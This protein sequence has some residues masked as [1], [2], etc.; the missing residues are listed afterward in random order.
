MMRQV[1]HIIP[2]LVMATMAVSC[3]KATQPEEAQATESNTI[4][5]DFAT[6]STW[7][8]A[9]SRAGI[10]IT[11]STTAG[12]YSWD[13]VSNI[14]ATN[15]KIYCTDDAANQIAAGDYDPVGTVYRAPVGNY[16]DVFAYYPHHDASDV[17]TIDGIDYPHIRNSAGTGPELLVDL[18]RQL[19]NDENGECYLIPFDQQSNVAGIST[20]YFYGKTE[21]TPVQRLSDDDKI[22]TVSVTMRH[23]L[24]RVVINIQR[25]PSLS[26]DIYFRMRSCYLEDAY[27]LIYFSLKTGLRSG[28]VGQPRRLYMCRYDPAVFPCGKLVSATPHSFVNSETA[29][30][31]SDNLSGVQ[32]NLSYTV[33]FVRGSGPNGEITPSDAVD[34]DSDIVERNGVIPLA[35]PYIAQWSSGYT[36]TYNVILS[37]DNLDVIQVNIAPW[38]KEDEDV[39]SGGLT[40]DN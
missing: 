24:T 32:L 12:E 18:H 11:S 15:Q 34:F 25:D 17:L 4:R 23:M 37:T 1:K 28:N 8:N 16:V 20:Q 33:S 39:F 31:N 3:S 38:F 22:T 14:L 10:Y 13:L 26:P 35:G 27:P 30:I 6:R 29:P 7:F 5:F 19:S 40:E 36:Y 2:L 21:R 9:D